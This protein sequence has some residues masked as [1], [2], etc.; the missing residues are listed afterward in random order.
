MEHEEFLSVFMGPARQVT[1]NMKDSKWNQASER[2]A[3]VTATRRLAAALLLMLVFPAHAV[4]H[5]TGKVTELIFRSSDGLIYFFLSGA[6]ASKP[7]CAT[8][9]YWVIAHE[10]SET[11]KRELALLLAARTSGMTITVNGRGTCSRWFDGE[12]VGLIAI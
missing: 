11:G 8:Q 10:N 7:V 6:A 5:Q 4:S 9:Q 1:K 3:A 2:R 12:D